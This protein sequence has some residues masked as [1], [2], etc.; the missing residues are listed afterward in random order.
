MVRV[1]VEVK[2]VQKEV[3]EE[4][5]FKQTQVREK[6]LNRVS[7]AKNIRNYIKAQLEIIK[8]DKIDMNNSDLILFLEEMLKKYDEMNNLTA[9][10]ELN[11]WKGK[12]EIE[13]I[14]YP[15]YFDIIQ[16]RKKDQDSQPVD[17][18]TEITKDEINR[19]IWAINNSEFEEDEKSKNVFTKTPAV[20]KQFCIA[21][22]LRHNKK[23]NVLI[24]D[25]GD[26]EW[27]HFFGDRHMHNNLNLCL[28]L[29]DYYCVINYRAGRIIKLKNILNIEE[30]K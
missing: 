17:V 27:Q 21:S 12:D 26:F 22:N 9:E 23:G 30:V 29:L 24:Y 6:L 2:S 16:H 11:N 7:T 10:V 20:A 5:H 3:I 19:V 14:E 28:R 8:K 13:F 18:H 4:R 1:D 25:N 15:E